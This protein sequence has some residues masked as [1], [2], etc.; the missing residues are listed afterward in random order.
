MSS[1]SHP[2]HIFATLVGNDGSTIFRHLAKGLARDS[3]LIAQ[4]KLRYNTCIKSHLQDS[5]ILLQATLRV[6]FAMVV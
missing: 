1:R 6:P 5:E 2:W 4:L 3:N